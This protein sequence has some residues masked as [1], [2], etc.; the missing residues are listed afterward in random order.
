MVYGPSGPLGQHVVQIVNISVDVRVTTLQTPM[1][2]T[3]AWDKIWT[4]PTVPGACVEEVSLS[5][6]L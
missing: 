3:T 1:V 2:A 4:A 6:Y 5:I